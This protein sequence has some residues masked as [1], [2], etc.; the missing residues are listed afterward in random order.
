[1]LCDSTN[2]PGI[3]EAALTGFALHGPAAVFAPS[4]ER[5]ARPGRPLEGKTVLV[6]ED[7]L[8]IGLEIVQTLEDLGA[9]V[10][11]PA[12]SLAQAERLSAEPGLDA[13]LVDVNLNGE[14]TLDLA[15]ALLRRG[16]QVVFVTA[17]ANESSL[18]GGELSAVPRVGKPASPPALRRVL[19]TLG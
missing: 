5:G 8:F 11:G 3:S 16:V 19:S 12:Q 13:A 18:F 17:Y 1:M 2:G 15:K 4:E 10:I 9:S 6:I 7:E 14:H